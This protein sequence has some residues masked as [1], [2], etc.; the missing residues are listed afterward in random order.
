MT[1]DDDAC[2]LTYTFTELGLDPDACLMDVMRE[3]DGEVQPTGQTIDLEL[4]LRAGHIVS[5]R[6][7]AQRYS[8]RVIGGEMFHT[9]HEQPVDMWVTIGDR[10]YPAYRIEDTNEQQ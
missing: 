7:P 10:E 6:V 2:C 1:L 4:W 8:S 3:C 5:V 9:R